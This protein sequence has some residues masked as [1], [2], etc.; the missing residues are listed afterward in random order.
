LPF[1]F[2]KPSSRRA[3]KEHNAR[4]EEGRDKRPNNLSDWLQSPRKR[5]KEKRLFNP[6]RGASLL[7]LGTGIRRL[8]REKKKIDQRHKPVIW[9]YPV[10]TLLLHP[11]KEA[12][13]EI[14][15]IKKQSQNRKLISPP[16]CQKDRNSKSK[17]GR[18]DAVATV[19]LITKVRKNVEER[20]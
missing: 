11:N 16:G 7:C 10:K 14:E 3:E 1:T 4:K 9:K 2:Q 19:Y 20:K 8:R 12:R 5:A 18:P 13:G 15:A 17:T 6:S